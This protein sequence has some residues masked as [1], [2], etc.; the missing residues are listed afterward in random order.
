MAEF[1][2]LWQVYTT[3]ANVKLCNVNVK[4]QEYECVTLNGE[5]TK[6]TAGGCKNDDQAERNTQYVLTLVS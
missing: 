6:E 3:S 2:S 5:W 4:A 1:A